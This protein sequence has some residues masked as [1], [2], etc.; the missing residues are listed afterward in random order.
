V[1][2]RFLWPFRDARLARLLRRSQRGERDAF[3]RLYS[4]LYEPV[5]RYVR[6]RIAIEADVEELVDQVFFRLLES[7]PSVDPNRSVLAYVLGVARNL[8]ADL[9]RRS[10]AP[11]GD[12]WMASIPDASAGP[13]ARLVSGEEADA[14]KAQLAALPN[15]VQ[16]VLTL[17]FCDELRYSQIA[18]MLGLSEPAARQRVSR[19]LRELRARWVKKWGKGAPADER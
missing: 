4:K 8:V 13:L 1:A 2:P 12:E 19:A 5:W 3:R 7:L 9:Q 11:R 17:R 15:E 18:E 16:E 14:I 10:F 6:R